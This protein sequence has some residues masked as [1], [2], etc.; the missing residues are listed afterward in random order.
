MTDNH[1]HRWR[2]KKRAGGYRLKYLNQW[3]A[4]SKSN[5]SKKYIIS[6]TYDGEWQCSCKGW[7][8]HVPRKDCIHIRDLKADPEAL[9]RGVRFA[10]VETR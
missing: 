6:L 5:P 1:C 10:A 7:T 3:E 9:C 4:P 8:M 2:L